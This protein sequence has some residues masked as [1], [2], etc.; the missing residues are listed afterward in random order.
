VT[1]GDRPVP[2]LAVD[3]GVGH[4]PGAVGGRP[5]RG[6]QP[7]ADLLLAASVG[8]PDIKLA[9][10]VVRPDAVG[11][12]AEPAQLAALLFQ[13]LPQKASGLPV[14]RL[15]GLVSGCPLDL[16]PVLAGTPSP[17]RVAASAARIFSRR[18]K[19]LVGLLNELERVGVA[20]RSATEPIDTSTPT[21]DREKPWE[22]RQRRLL[23]SLERRGVSPS[24]ERRK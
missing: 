1:L 17:S 13:E 5:V 9:W 11:H 12:P 18:D 15:P 23:D 14:G 22:A 10:P 3:Q 2:G 21:G 24:R 19:V 8:E 16:G 6:G 4:E 20:F 7:H